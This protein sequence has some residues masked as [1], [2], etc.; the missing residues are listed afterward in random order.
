MAEHDIADIEGLQVA[1]SGAAVT[2]HSWR[3]R[4]RRITSDQLQCFHFLTVSSG[5]VH[6]VDILILVS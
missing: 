1:S 5:S 3:Q 6:V 4:G 2:D